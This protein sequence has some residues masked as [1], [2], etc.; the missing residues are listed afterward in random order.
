M[1]RVIVGGLDVLINLLE[2]EDVKC[3]IG[4]LMVLKDISLSPQVKKAIADLDGI[5]PLVAILE[6]CFTLPSL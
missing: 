3:K 1:Y 4:A 5:R 6:V 2:T